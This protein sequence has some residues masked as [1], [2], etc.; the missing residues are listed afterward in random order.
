MSVS[1]V[2]LEVQDA[3][4]VLY[5]FVLL[6]TARSTLFP[7]TTL[8]RSPVEK[9][10]RALPTLAGNRRSSARSFAGLALERADERRLD[11]KSTRLNSSHMSIPYAVSCWKKKRSAPVLTQVCRFRCSDSFRHR[12]T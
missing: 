2:Q 3:C 12:R 1:V 11:R 7:Y 8:F 10:L 4:E 6:P 9:I 5:L